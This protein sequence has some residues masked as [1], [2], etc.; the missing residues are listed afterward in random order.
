MAMRKRWMGLLLMCSL[1][2]LSAAIAAD[3]APNGRFM[4]AENATLQHRGQLINVKK[5]QVI[6]S[7]DTVSTPLTGKAQW[8]M[9][10][11]TVFALGHS[12]SL[13]MDQFQLPGAG[14]S[15][16][17]ELTLNRGGFR[18]IA[19]A[20]GRGNNQYRV[21]TRNATLDIKGADFWVIQC[22]GDC[23]NSANEQ[24][25]DGVFVGVDHGSVEVANALGTISL[26]AGQYARVASPPTA[27][28]AAPLVYAGYSEEFIFRFGVGID[29]TFDEAPRIERL[30]LPSSNPCDDPGSASPSC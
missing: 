19:G 23:Y 29:D 12:S 6:G 11:D 25:P 5:G 30:S 18:S 14:G 27:Q 2:P 24:L 8:W 10:D 20:L 26:G 3:G 1:F 13:R 15:G 4:L 7:G 17:A 9:Q 21:N 16:K 22:S 28:P